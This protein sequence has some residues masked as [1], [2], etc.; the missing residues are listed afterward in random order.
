MNHLVP[1][2]KKEET[3]NMINFDCKYCDFSGDVA[4]CF[5]D[6]FY[7]PTCKRNQNDE[8][9]LNWKESDLTLTYYDTDSGRRFRSR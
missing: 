9:D 8:D 1:L 7:C 6:Q 2:N 5:P 4:D 3:K